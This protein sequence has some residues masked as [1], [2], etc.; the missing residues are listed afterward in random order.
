GAPVPGLLGSGAHG[1][2][3]ATGLLLVRPLPQGRQVRADGDPALLLLPGRLL[4]LRVVL[5][6]LDPGRAA[7]P[8]GAEVLLPGGAGRG[9]VDPH[10]GVG[11]E[12]QCAGG[13]VHGHR[14]GQPGADVAL[15]VPGGLVDLQLRADDASGDDELPG[16][17]RPQGERSGGI[18]AVL[19]AGH[20][21]VPGLGG[22][23]EQLGAGAV[24]GGRAGP[25]PGQPHGPGGDRRLLRAEHA[26]LPEVWARAH[27]SG[28]AAAAAVLLPRLQQLRA[29][30]LRVLH[31]LLLR[32]LPGDVMLRPH[33]RAVD[34]AG[35]L[36]VLGHLLDVRRGGLC[37][38]VP[39]GGGGD[40]GLGADLRMHHLGLR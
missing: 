7:E 15:L 40:F 38:A 12:D 39:G 9:H 5:P 34:H 6:G 10:L 3:P 13:M 17:G 25:R 2:R 19:P 4:P 31:G 35:L 1:P 37:S 18:P 36:G 24:P 30:V 11:G 22:G 8:L 27:H 16:G 20:H 29:E 14:Q 28:S 23:L 33:L 26:L 21:H 32:G